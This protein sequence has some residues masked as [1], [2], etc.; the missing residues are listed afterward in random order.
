MKTL[1]LVGLLLATP[2]GFCLDIP[3]R[4]PRDTHIQSTDYRADDVVALTAYTGMSTHIVFAPDEKIEHV[5]AGFADGWQTTPKGHHLFLKAISTTATE[6][7]FDADGKE[8][9]KEIVV[10]PNARAWK[11][12]LNVVTDKHNYSFALNLGVG[13]KGRRQNTY[14]LTF[15]YPEEVAKR[16][17]MALKRAQLRQKLTPTVHPKNW[18]YLM[19]VGKNARNIAPMAAF[20]DGRFTYLRFAQNSE[21]PAIFIE[22]ETGQETL[23]NAHI[24][25]ERPDTLVMQRI[26]KQWVLRLGQAVVGVTNQA[27]DTL[28]VDNRSGTTVR[29]VQ[30]T[31][32]E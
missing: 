3:D 31:L 14:R 26:A 1:L 9:Q 16:Q 32:K 10:S 19:Q 22:T 21:L 24:S 23:V 11:T 4:S 8:V 2:S 29:G 27:F 12:N 30:R 17:A 6:T 7:R 25:A 18:D 13:A 5:F 15:R 28:A 20:D